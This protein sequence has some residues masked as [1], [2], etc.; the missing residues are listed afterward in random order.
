MYWSCVLHH[1]AIKFQSHHNCTHFFMPIILLHIIHWIF[2]LFFL[3]QSSVEHLSCSVFAPAIT[4]ICYH[5]YHCF[6]LS[7]LHLSHI[8]IFI[9]SSPHPHPSSPHPHL[10]LTFTLTHL[11]GSLFILSPSLHIV[12]LLLYY[13]IAVFAV[14][15]TCF[16]TQWIYWLIDRIL[17]E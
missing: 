12:L 6:T 4:T 10:I 14:Y 17:C 8:T 9:Q 15:L 13:R 3:E 11:I 7:S 16:F 5:S 2:H 1:I